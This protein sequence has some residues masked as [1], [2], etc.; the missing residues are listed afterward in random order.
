[1]NTRESDRERV[2]TQQTGTHT[3]TQAHN[4]KVLEY[5]REIYGVRHTADR[6]TQSD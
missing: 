1:M 3:Y 4:N 6:H 2:T 5:E